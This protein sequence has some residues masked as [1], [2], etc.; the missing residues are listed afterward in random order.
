MTGTC[1][2]PPNRFPGSP[3]SDINGTDLAH[4]VSAT[5]LT[6]LHDTPPLLPQ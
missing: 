4:N 3:C 1:S 5:T 2:L 6:F